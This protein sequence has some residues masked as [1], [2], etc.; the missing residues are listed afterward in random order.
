MAEPV[1]EVV[2]ARLNSLEEQLA[3]VQ[4]ENARL[5]AAA[6]SGAM[7][8][9]PLAAAKVAESAPEP[10]GA[11]ARSARR[12][13]APEAAHH[14]ANPAPTPAELHPDVPPYP[15]LNADTTVTLNELLAKAQAAVSQG[16]ALWVD[17]RKR[18]ALKLYQV[19]WQHQ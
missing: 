10:A 13:A 14:D 17:K 7:K 2:A 9:L 12:A 8:A 11:S 3:A 4:R 6:A 18:A 16:E 1:S 19:S 15:G 5:K